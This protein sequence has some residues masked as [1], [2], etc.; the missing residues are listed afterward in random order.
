MM[1][2]KALALSALIVALAV[3]AA[4]ALWHELRA[5]PVEPAAAARAMPEAKPLAPA[6]E[7]YAEALFPIQLTVSAAALRMSFA[8][9]AYKTEDQDAHRLEE[10]VRPLRQ[11]F[12][13]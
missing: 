7:A 12:Q 11:E 9:L 2:V 1:R 3:P 4:Y 10:T 5:K 13:A 8:G 6:E